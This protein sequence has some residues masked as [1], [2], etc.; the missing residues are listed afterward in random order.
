MKH[1][2]VVYVIAIVAGGACDRSTTDCAT[3]FAPDRIVNGYDSPIQRDRVGDH[4]V[5]VVLKR[6]LQGHPVQQLC[7]GV[8][9]SPNEILT[10]AHCFNDGAAWRVE[11]ETTS[12]DHLDSTTCQ[13]TTLAQA[14]LRQLSTEL[15]IALLETDAPMLH[16]APFGEDVAAGDAALIAGFGLNEHREVG[17]LRFL[18]TTVTE[19]TEHYITIDSGDDAGACVGDSGGPLFHRV[20][21]D[22]PYRLIGI[23]SKGSLQCNRVDVY[24]GVV[25]IRRWL[26]DA[27]V[28]N[29]ANDASLPRR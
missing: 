20:S 28:L 17:V 29:N 21:D 24:T 22:A 8:A 4:I 1:V 26:S 13:P 23:L 3:F 19:V 2:L 27:A 10:A 9:I 15:D 16:A 6:A 18:D 25:P 14:T 7:S 12:P 11:I 5:K